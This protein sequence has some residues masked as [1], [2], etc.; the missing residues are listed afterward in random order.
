MPDGALPAVAVTVAIIKIFELPK[1]QGHFSS[2]APEKLRNL[3]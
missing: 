2:H 3:H 1:V